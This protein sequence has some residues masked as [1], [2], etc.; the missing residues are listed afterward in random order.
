MTLLSKIRNDLP[1][2]FQELIDQ[3]GFALQSVSESQVYLSSPRCLIVFKVEKLESSFFVEFTNPQDNSDRCDYY[4]LMSMRYP[5]FPRSLR[6]CPDSLSE[7]QKLRFKFG[8]ACDNL[9]R[10]CRDLLTGDFNTIRREGYHDLASYLQIHTPI[11]LNLPNDDPIKI[12][13]WRGD[14]SW[15]KDLMERDKRLM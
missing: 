11:A 6:K 1:K 12:K 10:Y 2:I 14:L 8:V 15:V 5:D 13:F 3:F 7:E 4:L 9:L